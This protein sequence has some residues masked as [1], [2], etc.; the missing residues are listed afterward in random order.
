MD[1][2]KWINHTLELAKEAIVSGNPPFGAL[3]E[4][5]GEVILT[6]RSTQITDNDCTAHAELNLARSAYSQLGMQKLARMTLY[7]STE[8]C[9]MCA[10]AIYWAGIRTVVFGCSLSRFAEVVGSSLDIDSR[11]IFR[12]ANRE[13]KV[14]GP[15]LEEEVLQIHKDFWNESL[16]T[17]LGKRH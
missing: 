2:E 17:Y 12:T 15:I 7:T 16:S 3:L 4:C 6:H 14:I 10:G 5:N 11:D 9:A 1:H 8:P 13:I